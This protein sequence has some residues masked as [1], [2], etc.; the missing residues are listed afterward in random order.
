MYGIFGRESNHKIH[1]CIWCVYTDVANLIPDLLQRL[2]PP[3]GGLE[4]NPPLHNL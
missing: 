2:H 4:L 3:D 1:L